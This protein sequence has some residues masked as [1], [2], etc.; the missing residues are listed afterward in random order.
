MLVHSTVQHSKAEY[1]RGE[2]VRKGAGKGGPKGMQDKDK[3]HDPKDKGKGGQGG[4]GAS[5]GADAQC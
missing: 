5:G 3:G 2:R 4:G 1:K